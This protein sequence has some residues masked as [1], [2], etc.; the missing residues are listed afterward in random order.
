M[1]IK[2]KN[3][4]RYAAAFAQQYLGFCL[5]NLVFKSSTP[6]QYLYLGNMFYNIYKRAS[7]T[8]YGTLMSVATI[9]SLRK[10]LVSGKN[11]QMEDMLSSYL[12]IKGSLALFITITLYQSLFSIV[13]S[14][15]F[16]E[17]TLET[18]MEKAVLVDDNRI[19]GIFADL[20]NKMELGD[21]VGIYFSDIVSGPSAASN[22]NVYVPEDFANATDEQI[23]GA[24]AHEL[25]HIK[26]GHETSIFSTLG[27]VRVANE[28]EADEAAAKEGVRKD[29]VGYLNDALKVYPLNENSGAFYKIR[30]YAEVLSANLYYFQSYNTHP[31]PILRDINM[32][33]VERFC[34]VNEG[35]QL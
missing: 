6:L 17:S 29:T 1:T 7:Y 21:E 3:L 33:I 23:R 28:Y 8:D 26:E 19:N 18:I 9:Y 27:F 10:R 30:H 31:A 13:I 15:L 11:Q 35:P 16:A 25:T 32:R 5:A 2:A 24:L 22:G 34:N 14:K 4:P 12:G 20:K